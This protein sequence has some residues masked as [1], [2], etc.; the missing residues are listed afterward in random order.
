MALSAQVMVNVAGECVGSQF[1]F[2]AGLAGV[3]VAVHASAFPWH[4]RT[5]HLYLSLV[6]RDRPNVPECCPDLCRRWDG[7]RRGQ[8]AAADGGRGPTT[9][10][11]RHPDGNS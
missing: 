6:Q 3:T 10:G 11:P 7:S 9:D 1:K 8:E 2:R 5:T 4:S